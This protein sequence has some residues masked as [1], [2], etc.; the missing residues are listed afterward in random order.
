MIDV[1]NIIEYV[2]YPIRNKDKNDAGGARRDK[3]SDRLHDTKYLCK[4]L[5]NALGG[6]YTDTYTDSI[7]RVSFKVEDGSYDYVV[8]I[9]IKDERSGETDTLSHQY[10]VVFGRKDEAHY[11]ELIN[12][13]Y[14]MSFDDISEVVSRANDVL[15]SR[16]LE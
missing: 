16:G 15:M 4:E 9:F 12:G 5:Q 8:S 11:N 14:Y 1:I 13:V 10:E 7:V 3:S 2:A 6:K